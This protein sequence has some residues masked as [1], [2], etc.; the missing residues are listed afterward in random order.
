M[1]A[2]VQRTILDANTISNDKDGYILD[3][4]PKSSVITSVDPTP[5]IP[6]VGYV[7]AHHF[8]LN[9]GGAESE[10]YKAA[11]IEIIQPKI[12][13]DLPSLPVDRDISFRAIVV[14]KPQT[15]TIAL[16]SCLGFAVSSGQAVGEDLRALYGA[17]KFKESEIW[18][19]S[20]C[21]DVYP[22]QS[23][24]PHVADWHSHV[25]DKDRSDLIYF[26][27]SAFPTE[28]GMESG[29]IEAIPANTLIRV[30]SEVKHRSTL[31]TGNKTLRRCFEGWVIHYDSV[32]PS[33]Y[34]RGQAYNNALVKPDHTRF[35]EFNEN[36]QGILEQQKAL[37]YARRNDILI[38]GHLVATMS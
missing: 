34:P 2:V 4:T 20:G 38:P 14:K 15:H 28:I 21:M 12:I 17:Q 19:V 36:A 3:F 13:A 31:N 9:G 18:F 8:R 26:A 30:G 24:L 10:P 32:H 11:R 16:P 35:A 29:D 7:D 6:A 25:N 33:A 27:S 5:G 37:G 22:E 1:N 23:L